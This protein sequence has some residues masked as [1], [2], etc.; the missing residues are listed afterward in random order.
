MF[1]GAGFWFGLRYPQRREGIEDKRYR[2]MRGRSEDEDKASC[3]ISN[4]SAAVS[5]V[6]N[7]AVVLE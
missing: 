3:T 5:P 4:E 6:L 2:Y 1:I 7:V